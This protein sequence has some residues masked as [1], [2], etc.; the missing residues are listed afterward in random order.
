MSVFGLVLVLVL[1][2]LLQ[3]CRVPRATCDLGCG[4][5]FTLV[6]CMCARYALRIHYRMRSA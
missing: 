3:P 6:A 2:V 4:L 1:C 5:L